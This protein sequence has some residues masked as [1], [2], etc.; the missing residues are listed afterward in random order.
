MAFIPSSGSVVA[1]Q[2]NPANLQASVTG[3]VAITSSVVTLVTGLQGA[4]VSGTVTAN[5]GTNPWVITGS[6]QATLAPA[7]NQSVSGT[8]GASVIGLTPVAVTNTPSI[9]G[10][11]LVGNTNVN[12]SGSVVSFI[13]NTPAVSV[14]GTVFVSGSVVTVGSSAPANQSVSGAVSVSNFP[15]TQ[16]VSGSVVAFQGTNPFIITGSVQGSFSAGNSS[17]QVLNF[18]ANQSVS[19]TVGASILGNVNTTITSVATVGGFLNVNLV[20]GSILT[21]STP[22]QSVSGTVQTDVRGSIAAVIIG[23][24]IAAS[25]IPPANQSVSGA[26]SIS[27]FPT[28]QNVSGSVVATQGTNP[29]IITG[30]VQGSFTPSGNQSVSGTVQ[31]QVQASVAVVII[32][33]SILTS[34]TANQSVSGT[35]GASIIGLTPVAVTNTPSISGTVNIGNTVPVTLSGGPSIS[36]TVIATQGTTPWLIGSVYGNV[37]GSIAGT[38]TEP[39]IATSITGLALVFKSNVSS[40][41]MTGVSVANPLP[42]SVQGT[43]GASII[44]S[45]PVTFPAV[46]NQ[47]VSGTVLVNNGS[48]VAFQGTGWS[49]SVAA[50]LQSSNASII[51]VGTAAPNQSV[52]GTVGSS[53]IGTVPVVQSGINITSIVSSIP[54]SVLVGASIFGQLPGGTA[55]LGSVVGIQGTN[56]YVM[57]GSVQ[58]TMSVLGTVPVTE[59]GTWIVSVVGTINVASSVLTVSVPYSGTAS[60]VSGWASMMTGTQTSII[61]A[62]GASI[63]TYVTGVQIANASATPVYLTFYGATSSVVGY[64]VA[65]ANGGSNIV[66]PNAWKTNANGAFSASVSGVASIFVSAEGFTSNV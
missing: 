54:S 38:Y 21:S 53:V 61:G 55:T 52:S 7:A 36:G 46:V 37:S 9:S 51:T 1:F 19:G 59:S 23:G 14:Q 8:V 6:V 2:S 58:G 31:T 16:N 47:S 13:N 15:T 25:F 50:W 11:V 40:S 27:N 60:W 28:T 35:V 43:I 26:V 12:V 56:P 48:V 18:P 20:G 64:S 39:N 10:T 41:V 3:T 49:G 65:P 63:F 33:G 62:G 5:Q 4:S 24:S 66:L 44:G 34:S 42:V 17:V 29:W 32:G 30:S 22:N 57:T 45:V